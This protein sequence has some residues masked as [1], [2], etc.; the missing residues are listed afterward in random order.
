VR[1]AQH[2]AQ[3]VDHLAQ[4]GR[5]RARTRPGRLPG[6]DHPRLLATHQPVQDPELDDPFD[7]PVAPE[8]VRVARRAGDESGLPTAG[9][10]RDRQAKIGQQPGGGAQQLVDPPVA[11]G[12]RQLRGLA[13]THAASRPRTSTM[14]PVE[15]ERHR[16]EQLD[17]KRDAG[18]QTRP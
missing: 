12:V 18:Q 4:G 17:H 16:D 7:L 13:V 1:R 2:A 8:A 3:L 11:I 14:D 6:P 15:D 10:S 5:S 9:I